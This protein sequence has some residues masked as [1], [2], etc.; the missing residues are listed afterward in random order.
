MQLTL[1]CHAFLM[2]AGNNLDTEAN[3]PIPGQVGKMADVSKTVGTD[4]L[5]IIGCP[6]LSLSLEQLNTGISSFIT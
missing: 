1:E 3:A 5:S 6:V 4:L 2:I